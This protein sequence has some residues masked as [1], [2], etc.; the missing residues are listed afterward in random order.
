VGRARVP[1][2]MT[3]ASAPARHTSAAASLLPFSRFEHGG[4][5]ALM[6]PLARSRWRAVPCH[7]AAL[8][9]SPTLKAALP[10]KQPYPRAALP[11]K[12]PYPQKRPFSKHPC[13]TSKLDILPTRRRNSAAAAISSWR[14]P[15]GRIAKSY[16]PSVICNVSPQT[17]RCRCDLAAA[18][19]AHIPR[20]SRDASGCQEFL[21]WSRMC[22]RDL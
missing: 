4:A 15:L 11:S 7:L 22:I 6:K 1:S 12:Q 5:A 3:A 20:M 21:S 14:C 9:E 2:P 16:P 8:S 13:R 10:S 17:V 19:F 18:W